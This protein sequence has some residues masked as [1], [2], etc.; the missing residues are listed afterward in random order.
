MSHSSP[1]PLSPQ[2]PLG[3]PALCAT[4]SSN[5]CDFSLWAFYMSKSL[6]I[7]SDNESDH[8]GAQP[9]HQSRSSPP[10]P[11]PNK[12]KRAA[13]ESSAG[14]SSLLK[15]SRIRISIE[16][17]R[18]VRLQA[19]QAYFQCDTPLAALDVL[20]SYAPTFS[21]ERTTRYKLHSSLFNL[22]QVSHR[23]RAARATE[24]GQE[25]SRSQSLNGFGAALVHLAGP[26]LRLCC[27]KVKE[28]IEMFII[29]EVCVE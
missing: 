18:L 14:A 22:R 26:D 27:T 9:R 3:I 12:R 29:R 8:S 23:P 21:S 17:E 19:C 6:A 20:L 10:S 24:E 28:V 11:R 25:A 2:S 1:S 5:S 13:S 16:G 15:R 7:G 4:Q